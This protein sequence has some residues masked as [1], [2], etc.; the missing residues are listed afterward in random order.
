[1]DPKQLTT[2]Y[3]TDNRALS[4][5]LEG[6]FEKVFIYTSS[7]EALQVFKRE[8]IDLI[9]IDCVV[10]GISGTDFVRRV[11]AKSWLGPV[12]MITPYDD[13]DFFLEAINIG[14]TQFVAEPIE[15][16]QL[17][18]VIELAVVQAMENTRRRQHYKELDLLK[19]YN[20]EAFHKELHIMCNEYDSRFL[21]IKSGGNVFRWTIDVY[22]QSSDIISG[23]A[24]SVRHLGDTK[25]FC[26]VLDAM[27]TGMG[28]SVTSMVATSFINYLVEKQ[29]D[30][31][32]FTG[33]IKEF[34]S[35]IKKLLLKDEILCAAL[36]LFDFEEET[37][38]YASFSM[39]KLWIK[40]SDQS[41]FPLK[42]NNMPI[43]QYFPLHILTT[44]EVSIKDVAKILVTSDGI[45]EAHNEKHSYDEYIKDDFVHSSTLAVFKKLFL[46]RFEPEDDITALMI[47]RNDYRLLWE[48][49]CEVESRLENLHILDKFFMQ[50]VEKAGIKK[51]DQIQLTISFTEMVMN[52]FEHGNLGLDLMEKHVA[53]NSGTYDEL[54]RAREYKYGPKK[55]TVYI[56]LM[57]HASPFIRIR[58]IDEGRGI[59]RVLESVKERDPMLL[60]GRGIEII[61]Q[62]VDQLYY[63][64]KGNEIIVMKTLTY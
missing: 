8:L 32:D 55:I 33:M 37:M 31:V 14:V 54:I 21:E 10:G 11:R 46:S 59:P 27:D 25:A 61:R 34:I 19:Y 20:M 17:D 9:V 49:C 48:E 2:L 39:P 13:K 16:P 57:E 45:S 24:Y 26:F 64:P 7:E 12:L 28:A 3:V 47:S 15:L 56:A 63:S 5:Y 18:R 40:K 58:V 36:L 4:G 22:Y 35:Y 38:R 52:A 53:L 23:D 1:M 62:Y 60:C 30:T 6:R 43:S 44:D 41:V 29:G 51:D 50:T 42:S